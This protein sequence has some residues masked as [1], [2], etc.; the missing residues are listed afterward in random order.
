MITLRFVV[1]PEGSGQANVTFNVM[2]STMRSVPLLS[3]A[4]IA[5]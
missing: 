1:L 3:R 2:L 5:E 4:T